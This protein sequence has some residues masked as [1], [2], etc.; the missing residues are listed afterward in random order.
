MLAAA[1]KARRIHWPPARNR[2]TFD[3]RFREM[4]WTNI[5][6]GKLYDVELMKEFAARATPPV[7]PSENSYSCVCCEVL[8]SLV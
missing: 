1:L 6:V 2:N 3:A 4:T 7:T 8:W 5:D